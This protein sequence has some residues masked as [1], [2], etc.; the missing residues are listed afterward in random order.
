MSG[1]VAGSSNAAAMGPQHAFIW[2]GGQLID[3]GTLGGSACADCNSG[4]DGPNSGG[5][6][7]VGSETSARRQQHQCF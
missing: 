6:A 5:E 1:M 3:L 4:T 7:A 2:Y